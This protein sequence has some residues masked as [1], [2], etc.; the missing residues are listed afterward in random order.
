MANEKGKVGRLGWEE[1]RAEL[2][3]WV[4]FIFILIDES[5]VS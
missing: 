2:V 1:V 5:V 4:R 3:F